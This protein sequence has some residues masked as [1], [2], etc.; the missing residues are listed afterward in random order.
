MGGKLGSVDL[1]CSV[2]LMR[3]FIE[4]KGGRREQA[5]RRV[6]QEVGGDEGARGASTEHRWLRDVTNFRG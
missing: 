4:K 5:E 3:L 2:L 1:L 6:V